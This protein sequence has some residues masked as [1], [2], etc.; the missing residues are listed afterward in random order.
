MSLLPYLLLP[1]CRRSF[2]VSVAKKGGRTKERAREGVI[3]AAAGEWGLGKHEIDRSETKERKRRTNVDI[4]GQKFPSGGD[5][6]KEAGGEYVHRERLFGRLDGGGDFWNHSHIGS[7]IVRWDQHSK[8][9]C[10]GRVGHLCPVDARAR[11]STS[12]KVPQGGRH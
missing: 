10:F 11:K 3:G 5:G 12:E 1:F 6:R 8:P 2:I 9:I 4:E 7:A